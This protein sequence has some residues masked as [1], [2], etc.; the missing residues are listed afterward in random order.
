[1]HAKKETMM[2]N[3]RDNERGNRAWR[4]YEI[5]NILA[6]GIVRWWAFKEMALLLT[7]ARN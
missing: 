3:A 5:K 1:M 4:C 2:R 7:K 6:E